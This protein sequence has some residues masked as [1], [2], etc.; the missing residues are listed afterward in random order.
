MDFHNNFC[1]DFFTVSPCEA[2][3]E[4]VNCF[5][6]PGAFP[7]AW[8]E[9]VSLLV[10]PDSEKPW[11][12]HFLAG[13]ESPK[14]ANFYSDLPS[15]RDFVIVSKGIAYIVSAYNPQE[16]TEL[17]LRPVLDVFISKKT[18]AIVLVGY[19]NLLVL[20]R[21]GS[22]W[23]TPSLS[24]DGIKDIEESEGKII[25]KGW[26]ASIGKMVPFEID[27]TTRSYSGGAAPPNY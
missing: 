12:G 11:V 9:G 24:W 18:Q 22:S 21:D 10:M 14:G 6:Y 23:F 26:D 17:K 8:V 15:G 4:A 19:T 25:G 27:I 16:W 7:N 2:D 3:V 1:S 20:M 5:A 13:G